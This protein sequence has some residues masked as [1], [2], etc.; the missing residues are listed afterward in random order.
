MCM[1][2]TCAL[3]I[4]TCSS[5]QGGIQH[6]FEPQLLW[7]RQSRASQKMSAS[8]YSSPEPAE[9]AS[10]SV[11]SSLGKVSKT[12]GTETFRGVPPFSVNFFPLGFWEPTVRGGGGGTP[13][14]R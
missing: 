10:V 8:P 12:P 9:N 6:W 7:A 11:P 14:F 13:L 2:M 5:L 4:A 1:L 3:C